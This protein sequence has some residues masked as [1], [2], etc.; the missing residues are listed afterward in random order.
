VLVAEDVT[1]RFLNIIGLFNGSI[2]LVWVQ[3][4]TFRISE[5]EVTVVCTTVVDELVRGLVDEDEEIQETADR[6]YWEAR[7]SKETLALMDHLSR[8][9]ARV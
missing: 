3:M 9:G 6:T 1:S 5:D 8:I 4:Q 2:P 7:A